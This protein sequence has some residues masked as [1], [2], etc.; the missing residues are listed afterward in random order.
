MLIVITVA[1]LLIFFF[2]LTFQYYR[3]GSDE[4]LN[5]VSCPMTQETILLKALCPDL[6]IPHVKELKN[7][8]KLE[9]IGK[10]TNCRLRWIHSIGS[11]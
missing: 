4:S 1:R 8:E 7:F 5:H 10:G 2:G 9:I 6:G 3:S 11:C